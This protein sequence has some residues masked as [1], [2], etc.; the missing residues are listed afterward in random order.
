VNINVTGTP[1]PIRKNN[2]YRDWS[3]A[4]LK[5]SRSIPKRSN[6]GKSDNNGRYNIFGEYKK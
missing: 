3:P 4:H 2:R 6:L 1:R 5:R